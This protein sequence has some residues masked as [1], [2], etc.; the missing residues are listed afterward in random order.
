MHLAAGVKL[1]FLVAVSSII[2]VAFSWNHC[3]MLE[4]FGRFITL[5]VRQYITVQPV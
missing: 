5:P 3:S 1:K 2:S 4:L